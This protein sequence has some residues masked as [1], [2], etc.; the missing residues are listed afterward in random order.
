MVQGAEDDFNCAL[1]P[2]FFSQTF[3]RLFAFDKVM[4]AANSGFDAP[5]GSSQT[6]HSASKAE[7]RFAELNRR[8]AS[9]LKDAKGTGR[10]SGSFLKTQN[11]A[12][13]W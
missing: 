11:S 13:P 7:K 4:T 8:C 3:W 10:G 9:A 2:K 5:K 1:P 6:I 12:L